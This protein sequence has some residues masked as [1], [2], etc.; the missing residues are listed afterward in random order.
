MQDNDHVCA[1]EECSIGLLGIVQRSVVV[2]L[3]ALVLRIVHQLFKFFAEEMDLSKI[4]G[5]KISE[6]WLVNKVIVNAEVEGMVLGLGW[7]S[8]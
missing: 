6:E 7:V 8:V 4:K 3:V 2:D 1:H 5:A